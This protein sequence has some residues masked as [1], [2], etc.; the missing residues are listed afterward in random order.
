MTSATR[1]SPTSRVAEASNVTKPVPTASS[2]APVTRDLPPLLPR[3]MGSRLSPRSGVPS[4]SNTSADDV[5]DGAECAP[6]LGA[7]TV[8]SPNQTFQSPSPTPSVN[9]LAAPHKSASSVVSLGLAV[10]YAN[11]PYGVSKVISV[12]PRYFFYSRL[13]FLVLVKDIKTSQTLKL[14][15]SRSAKEPQVC[16]S[17]FAKY[18]VVL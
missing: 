5:V 13:P 16:S 10:R 12:V 11:A 17:T 4:A 2:S 6:V 1:G 7:R 9:Q 15:V 18:P 14:G 3:A 8:I